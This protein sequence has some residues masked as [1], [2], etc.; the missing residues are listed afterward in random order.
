MGHDGSYQVKGVVENTLDLM[1]YSTFPDGS[2]PV[3]A[4][5]ALLYACRG[6]NTTMM[7]RG[8]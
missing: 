4:Q 6:I 7:A 5:K 8:T 3:D 1:A 2:A